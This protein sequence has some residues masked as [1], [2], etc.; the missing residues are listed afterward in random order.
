MPS[1]EW[2]WSPFTLQPFG[3]RGSWESLRCR[4]HSIGDKPVYILRRVNRRIYAWSDGVLDGLRSPTRS[5]L[6]SA[7]DLPLTLKAPSSN[8]K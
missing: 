6:G 1:L 5:L 4:H 8:F 2:W 3:P 7:E